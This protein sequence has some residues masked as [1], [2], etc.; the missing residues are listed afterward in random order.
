MLE[1][2]ASRKRNDRLRKLGIK[3]EKSS[4]KM[5]KLERELAT[6]E[7]AAQQKSNPPSDQ[8][9]RGLR[10]HCRGRQHGRGKPERLA[11]KQQS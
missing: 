7:K 2:R 8:A 3:K 9:P 5:E 6:Q 1:A 4:A 11:T 10:Q